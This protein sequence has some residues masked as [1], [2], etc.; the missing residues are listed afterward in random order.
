M[1]TAEEIKGMTIYE[2]L[3]Q[4]Q[5]QLKVPKDQ[6]NDFGGYK[7]RT[8]S[9]ILEAL[10][11][12]LD[13]GCIVLQDEMVQLGDRFYVKATATFHWKG[14]TVSTSAWAREAAVKK[15]MDDAQVTGACSSYARKYALG[16]L[17]AIDDSDVDPDRTN[18]HGTSGNEVSLKAQLLEV[19][20][21][22]CMYLKDDSGTSPHGRLTTK[23]D[24]SKWLTADV[25]KDIEA[26]TKYVKSWENKH[27]MSL[28]TPEE[29][30]AR[31]ENQR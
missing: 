26:V 14:G 17:A 29:V 21:H 20:D 4:I 12:H 18:R 8:A 13:G 28:M 2:K 30:E 19:M 24:N 10:K 16:A 6:R 15:G 3:G 5:Q 9:G 7:Y 31:M 22:P 1:N 23:H 27:Q 25:K 11:P